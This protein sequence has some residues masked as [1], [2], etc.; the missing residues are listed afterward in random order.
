MR[1]TG[2]ATSGGTAQLALLPARQHAARPASTHQG[3]DLPK[4]LSPGREASSRYPPEEG[5]SA[6]GSRQPAAAAA[7]LGG[8][9]KAAGRVP[10]ELPAA[11][12]AAGR[13]T[14]PA[15]RGP[16][17][18]GAAALQTAAEGRELGTA[19]GLAGTAAASRQ[20][21]RSGAAELETEAAAAAD[22]K[23]ERDWSGMEVAESMEAAAGG[24]GSAGCSM[25][26]DSA[27]HMHWGPAVRK[28]ESV[29]E[30]DRVR[31]VREVFYT[32]TR[33]LLKRIKNLHQRPVESSS[34]GKH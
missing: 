11:A 29:G 32:H 34:L 1:D 31:A 14:A 5:G 7:A 17:S 2:L 18:E 22:T 16:G 3:K 28:E 24:E 27:A 9:R 15:S 13:A 21:V 20:A 4:L 30:E 6:A 33:V 19:D 8:R 10:R 23:A 25:E 12:A 26:S